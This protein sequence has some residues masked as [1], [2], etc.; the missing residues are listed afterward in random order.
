MQ[1]PLPHA[2]KRRRDVGVR[3]V[4]DKF[5][6]EELPC[7]IFSHLFLLPQHLL[8]YRNQWELFSF[9]FGIGWGEG[10]TSGWLNEF[11]YSFTFT[12]LGTAMWRK[13]EFQEADD[14]VAHISLPRLDGTAWVSWP[15]LSK[16]FINRRLSLIY[17]QLSPH[18]PQMRDGQD[19]A[20]TVRVWRRQAAF[21]H[22]ERGLSSLGRNYGYYV[23]ER[24]FL[25]NFVQQN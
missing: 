22:G 10:K 24:L 19:N 14:S 21:C 7:P 8:S 18:Y 9:V 1:L 4:R 23:L 6:Q 25:W 16:T 2:V 15:W 11:H 17:F 12:R 20:F 5:V 13:E 3:R